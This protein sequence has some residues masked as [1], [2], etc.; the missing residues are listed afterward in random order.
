MQ[1]A[2]MY[3]ELELLREQVFGEGKMVKKILLVFVFII[4]TAVGC[5]PKKP[6]SNFQINVSVSCTDSS[7]KIVN[8]NAGDP[9]FPFISAS[10]Q[11]ISGWTDMAC[12]QITSEDWS[13]QAEGLSSVPLE[14]GSEL[15]YYFFHI[16][17]EDSG[18][19]DGIYVFTVNELARECLENQ[20]N[21]EIEVSCRVNDVINANIIT[22][23]SN[24]GVPFS[25]K[26]K[27]ID[28]WQCSL[29]DGHN[30]QCQSSGMVDFQGG[31]EIFQIH[32]RTQEKVSPS[33]E[34]LTVLPECNAPSTSEFLECNGLDKYTLYMTYSPDTYPFLAIYAPQLLECDSEAGS[35]TCEVDQIFPQLTPDYIR[36]NAIFRYL[37]G[38]G[39][40]SHISF[41]PIPDCRFELGNAIPLFELEEIGCH[42]ASQMFAMMTFPG[43]MK[44]EDVLNALTV[45]DCNAIYKCYPVEGL[46][47]ELY[48]VGNE[49]TFNPVNCPI[50]VCGSE[51]E[52]EVCK[53]LTAPIALNCPVEM[54][55]TSQNVD[56]GS[57]ANSTTCKAAGCVWHAVM[58]GSPFCSN[59]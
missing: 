5:A 12:T 20:T 29:Q 10:F 6:T 32:F 31:Y 17:A 11:S 30:I 43:T 28:N 3:N 51:G 13:C 2:S 59:K 37:D 7:N 58:S 55:P 53:N 39:G 35:I 21:V 41:V 9:G 46:S 4:L 19:P 27:A 52:K 36:T 44:S 48:C 56:C 47:Q 24:T 40:F 8:I 18:S 54:A 38:S 25:V 49:A 26:S 50:Q 22:N 42:S 16:K 57:F 1:I 33:Q 34:Y 45:R 14:V 15:N 23:F